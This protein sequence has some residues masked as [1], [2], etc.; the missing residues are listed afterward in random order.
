MPIR[1]SCRDISSWRRSYTFIGA[2]G[3]AMESIEGPRVVTSVQSWL[4][5]GMYLVLVCVLEL[6]SRPDPPK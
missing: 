6:C 5:N 1:D 3:S 4:S 2:Q